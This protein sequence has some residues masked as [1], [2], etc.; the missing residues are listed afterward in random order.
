MTPIPPLPA[1]S[2]TRAS[3]KR[4]SDVLGESFDPQ[5]GSRRIRS[6]RTAAGSSK[7][8]SED[9]ARRGRG[10]RPHRG[11]RSHRAGHVRDHRRKGLGGGKPCGSRSPS[12]P[13]ASRS[14]ARTTARASRPI[15]SASRSR[16]RWPSA[17][18]ITAPR[19]AACLALDW[20]AEAAQP[21]PHPRSS[22]PAPACWPSR[23]RRRI[24]RGVLASDIDP[25]AVRVARENARLN[26]CPDVECIRATGLGAA[27]F[28]RRAPFDLVFANILLPPLRRLAAR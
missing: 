22:A 23:P 9:A 2:A 21:A 5:H 20:I 28:A 13:A 25:E 15:A 16:P 26:G 19:A 3:A 10:A 11:S 17:P 24:A 27:R 6:A 4:L 18:A 1:S 14:M 7:S 12:R 8:I